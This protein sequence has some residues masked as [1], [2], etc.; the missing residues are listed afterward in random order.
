MIHLVTDGNSYSNGNALAIRVLQG[1][2]G[3]EETL[4]NSFDVYPNPATDVVNVNFKEV[5]TASVSVMNV[6]GKEVMSASVN[7][8]QTSFSTVSLSNGVYFVKVDNGAS[9]QIKKIVVKK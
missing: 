7:G 3:I 2:A 6:A 8:T 9:T 1:A 5:T 4:N